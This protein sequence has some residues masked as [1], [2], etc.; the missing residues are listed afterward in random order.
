MA[1]NQTERITVH[2]YSESDFQLDLF[3]KSD[4]ADS[5]SPHA[6]KLKVAT[7][8]PIKAGFRQSEESYSFEHSNDL[9]RFEN[10]ENFTDDQL[11]IFLDTAS[12]EKTIEDGIADEMSNMS[13]VDEHESH[14]K[15]EPFNKNI[16]KQEKSVHLTFVPE[17]LSS[18]EENE[19]NL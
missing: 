8:T 16:A 9:K 13:F 17:A 10:V 4:I 12:V 3:N 7:S 6:K 1:D 14:A 2:T 5:R 11:N 15:Q 18:D 19:V